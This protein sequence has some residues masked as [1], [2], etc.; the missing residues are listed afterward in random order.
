V[1][2][3]GKVVEISREIGLLWFPC[4]V[5]IQIILVCSQIAQM[6]YDSIY[7]TLDTNAHSWYN[8]VREGRYR[9]CG[10]IFYKEV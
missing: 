10:F 6:S 8:E 2:V 4:F 1:I 7:L 9:N 3:K 5:I